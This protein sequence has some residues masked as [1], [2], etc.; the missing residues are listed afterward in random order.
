MLHYIEGKADPICSD[1]TLEQ[2]QGPGSRCGERGW[3][4]VVLW[5]YRG[6]LLRL[7]WA[8]DVV[9]VAVSALVPSRVGDA[10]GAP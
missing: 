6:L 10:A 4:D 1:H 7:V 5:L 3:G 9:V 8:Q 2:R